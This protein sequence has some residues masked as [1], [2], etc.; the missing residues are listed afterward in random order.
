MGIPVIF[1]S[2]EDT[3][4]YMR[5]VCEAYELDYYADMALRDG[6]EYDDHFFHACDFYTEKVEVL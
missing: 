4:K 6:G 5:D 1:C 3:A 2:S